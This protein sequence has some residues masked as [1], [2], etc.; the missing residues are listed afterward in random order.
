MIQVGSLSITTDVPIVSVLVLVSE[1]ALKRLAGEFDLEAILV[2]DLSDKGRSEHDKKASRL[3]RCLP[4]IPLTSGLTS[5]GCIPQCIQLRVL[6]LSL[7]QLSSL[8]PLS[9]L[10]SLQHL[11]LSANEIT[12]IGQM[13][14]SASIVT[15]AP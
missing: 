8:S 14:N 4:N 10:T 11:D 12:S 3:V 13:T 7:N 5:C 2:L 9:T 1:D 15:L 6:N